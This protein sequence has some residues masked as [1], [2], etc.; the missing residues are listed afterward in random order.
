M[1]K[2]I[3][4]ISNIP[5]QYLIIGLATTILMIAMATTKSIGIADMLIVLI[6]GI[7]IG[8][9]MYFG[10]VIIKGLFSGFVVI[11]FASIYTFFVMNIHGYITQPFLLS[12]TAVTLFLAQ[13]YNKSYNCGLRS[14]ALWSA[15]LAVLLVS[16]KLTMIMYGYSFWITEVIGLNFAVIY[17]I[18]WRIWIDNSKKTKIIEPEIIDKKTTE[19]FKYVYINNQLN[20]QENLWLPNKINSYPYIYSNVMKAQEENKLFVIISKSKSSNVY[21]IGEIEISK[22]KKI[23]YLYMEDKDGEYHDEIIEEFVDKVEMYKGIK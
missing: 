1:K 9:Q 7:L 5:P 11:Y 2:I 8:L 4:K 14:R 18:S 3:D 17:I 19:N 16:I 23:Y 10:S 15:V 21:D 13:T 22:A 6:I 12:I 20:V